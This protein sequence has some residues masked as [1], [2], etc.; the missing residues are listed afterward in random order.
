MHQVCRK[1]RLT[2]FNFLRL[3]AVTEEGT[4]EVGGAL[5]EENIKEML[6]REYQFYFKRGNILDIYREEG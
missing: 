4:V 1:E 5:H 6:N 3:N 2:F